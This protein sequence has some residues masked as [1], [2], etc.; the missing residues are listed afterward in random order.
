MVLRNE[1]LW[2]LCHLAHNRP[3]FRATDFATYLAV[4]ERFAAA[5]CEEA[6]CED[7]LIL[8]QDYHFAL[9]PAMI[10]RRLPRATIITFWHI[11]WPNAERFGICPL[12]S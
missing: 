6:E 10:R 7:P 11:P 5:V 9:A 8:V 3:E 2:A 4:N 12:A 1:G